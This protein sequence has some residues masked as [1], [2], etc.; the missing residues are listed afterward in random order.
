[1]AL[2]HSI[3]VF[4]LH[5]RTQKFLDLPRGGETCPC[6]LRHNAVWHGLWSPVSPWSVVLC[7]SMACGPLSLY[8]LWS[9]VPLWPVVLCPSMACGPLSLYGLGS[10]VF[11]A[12]HLINH[13]NSH[14]ATHR[15][16][17]CESV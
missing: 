16:S 1:M 9:S 5:P 15:E 4:L 17:Q 10:P 2:L 7:P 3:R 12:D 14:Y 6:S 11:P 8:G 13:Y